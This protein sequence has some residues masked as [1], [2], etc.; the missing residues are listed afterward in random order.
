MLMVK[1]SSESQELE[2]S[3]LFCAVIQLESETVGQ[4]GQMKVQHLATRLEPKRVRPR[5]RPRARPKA[6]QSDD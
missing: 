2:L 5:A 6:W 3:L 4:L 1:E